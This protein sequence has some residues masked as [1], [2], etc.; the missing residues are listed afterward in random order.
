LFVYFSEI[1]HELKVLN[2]KGT[3]PTLSLR[4][5]LAESDSALPTF[6]RPPTLFR[7]SGPGG[8][9]LNSAI[10]VCQRYGTISITDRAS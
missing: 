2:I 3:P 4:V 10:P 1:L 8:D 9:S 5:C 7:M 6:T